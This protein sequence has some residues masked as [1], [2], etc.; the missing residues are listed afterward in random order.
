MYQQIYERAFASTGLS[1]HEEIKDFTHI[2]CACV[3]RCFL[4]DWLLV[5][6]DG[7]TL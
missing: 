2:I 4:D 7:S 1:K 5:A 3:P 6:G